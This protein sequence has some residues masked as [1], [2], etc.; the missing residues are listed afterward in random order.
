MS[1]SRRA[2]AKLWRP[3]TPP[4][5]LPHSDAEEICRIGRRFLGGGKRTSNG[6][7]APHQV[8]AE[9][10]DNL[11]PPKTKKKVIITCAVTGAIHTPSMSPYLPITAQEIADAAIGAAEAGAAA[12]PTC[13][14]RMIRSD[15]GRPDQ[16]AGG[17]RAVPQGERKRSNV[18][19]N[20]TSERRADHDGGRAGAVRPRRSSRGGW[21]LAQHGHDELRPLSDDDPALQGCKFKYDWEEPYPRKIEEGHVQRNSALPT[22]NTF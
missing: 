15:F 6:D 22:S 9:R 14:P 5:R 8:Q 21:A 7:A 17:V 19:I 12:C 16:T 13:M 10:S 2:A 4:R 11:G 18:V 20:L 3:R 1:M